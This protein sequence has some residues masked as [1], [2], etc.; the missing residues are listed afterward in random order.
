MQLSDNV[1]LAILEAC[2]LSVLRRANGFCRLSREVF[3]N[4]GGYF[5]SF[6]YSEDYFIYLLKEEKYDLFMYFLNKGH[7]YVKD[8]TLCNKGGF[9][10]RYC[11]TN[12]K[13]AP[14]NSRIAG[15]LS[16]IGVCMNRC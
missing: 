13:K 4:K 15:Y 14:E 5:S 7:L 10:I 3:L 1:L 2:S 16:K 9:E 11:Y 6:L 8:K 12:R